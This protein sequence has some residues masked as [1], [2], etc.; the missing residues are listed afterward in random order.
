MRE[1]L[2]EAAA[3]PPAE[4][5]PEVAAPMPPPVVVSAPP[6]LVR[7]V[8]PRLD[9]PPRP[10]ADIPNVVPKD[11]RLTPPAAIPHADASGSAAPASN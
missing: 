7:D 4:P 6:R 1:A 10:P 8:T 9:A 3:R 11:E 5:Q 2:R